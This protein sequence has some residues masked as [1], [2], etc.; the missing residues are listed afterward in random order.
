MSDS[1]AKV[2]LIYYGRLSS[3]PVAPTVIRICGRSD[4]SLTLEGSHVLLKDFFSL[5]QHAQKVAEFGDVIPKRFSGQKHPQPGVLV[6]L[7]SQHIPTPYH[8]SCRA[9]IEP[10]VGHMLLFGSD[11]VNTWLTRGNISLFD[12]TLEAIEQH[13]RSL[14]RLVMI[15]I[16]GP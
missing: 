3:R 16:P 7:V 10:F 6:S 13:I 15:A 2:V 11:R 8:C 4:W 14:G 1:R 12:A 5:I 9:R